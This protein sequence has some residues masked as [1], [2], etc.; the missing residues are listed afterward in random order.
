MGWMRY[1]QGVTLV[2]SLTWY[3]FSVTSYP[4]VRVSWGGLGQERA[5]H[6]YGSGRAVFGGP[7][8][9]KQEARAGTH[10][11][12]RSLVASDMAPSCC[13]PVRPDIQSCF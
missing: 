4:P 3:L 5:G 11:E 12:H 8:Q 7:G 1:G 10:T 2:I 6:P 13:Q 9:V